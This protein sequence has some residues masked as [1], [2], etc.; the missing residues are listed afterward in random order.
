MATVVVVVVAVVVVVVSVATLSEVDAVARLDPPDVAA[1]VVTIEVGAGFAVLDIAG[2][3]VDETLRLDLVV[4]RADT[5]VDGLLSKSAVEESPM[6]TALVVLE[7]LFLGLV[8]SNLF[9]VS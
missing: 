5:R 2:K 7:L 6:T 1:D 8:P 3:D 9:A 4:E